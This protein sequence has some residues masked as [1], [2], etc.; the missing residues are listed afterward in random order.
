[1]RDTV[2]RSLVGAESALS[3]ASFS[4]TAYGR[5][6]SIAD[7][8]DLNEHIDELQDLL[9]AFQLLVNDVH[10]RQAKN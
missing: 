4:L 5:W 1:M 10:G 6:I 8:Q 3:S 9:R 2:I 7:I